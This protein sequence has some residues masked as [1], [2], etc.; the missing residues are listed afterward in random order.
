MPQ[1]APTHVS[2][3]TVRTIT[4]LKIHAAIGVDAAAAVD[5]GTSVSVCALVMWL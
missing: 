4:E 1:V 5:V 3:A 2:I